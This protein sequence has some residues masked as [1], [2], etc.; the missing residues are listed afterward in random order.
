[1]VL[2]M[3]IKKKF[4]NRQ[5]RECSVLKKNIAQMHLYDRWQLRVW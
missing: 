4:K 3:L 2:L 5:D 1:M